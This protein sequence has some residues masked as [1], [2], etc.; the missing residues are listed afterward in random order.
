MPLSSR[1]TSRRSAHCTKVGYRRAAD[2]V[3]RGQK[4]QQW[5]LDQGDVLIAMGAFLI[6]DGGD[7]L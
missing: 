3:V 1:R 4:A 2:A 6:V 5:I 7:R